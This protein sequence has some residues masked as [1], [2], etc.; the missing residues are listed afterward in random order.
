MASLTAWAR[1]C[2]ELLDRKVAS[3]DNYTVYTP[4][5]KQLGGQWN[6]QRLNDFL[7][8]PQ[9]MVPGTSMVFP[10]IDDDR[11]RAELVDYVMAKSKE[12]GL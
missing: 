10:G 6:K 12:G 11:Q 8:D 3:A 9:G 2:A 4:A 5:L 1:T 7:R